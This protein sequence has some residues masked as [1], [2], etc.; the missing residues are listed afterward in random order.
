MIPTEQARRSTISFMSHE[1]TRRIQVTHEN[2]DEIRQM[3][4]NNVVV[5]IYDSNIA[6][7]WVDLSMND[8]EDDLYN[9]SLQVGDF[10]E[11]QIYEPPKEEVRREQEFIP[12][13]M[14]EVD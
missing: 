10:V 3:I 1:E 5:K 8:D 9:I 11:R 7:P 12:S 4:L 13:A 2:I 6:A 14:E